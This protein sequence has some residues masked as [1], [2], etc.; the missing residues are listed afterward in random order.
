M[1]KKLGRGKEKMAKARRILLECWMIEDKQDN[2]DWKF[3][4]SY[5]KINYL[6]N[7]TV[8]E[9]VPSGGRENRESGFEGDWKTATN[10]VVSKDKLLEDQKLNSEESKVK[11]TKVTEEASDVESIIEE[12]KVDNLA[13]D[14]EVK[15][16]YSETNIYH[17]NQLSYI[18]KNN[19]DNWERTNFW[20]ETKN[21]M[22]KILKAIYQKHWL[23][24]WDI[25]WKASNDNT[26]WHIVSLKNTKNLAVGDLKGPMS[27]LMEDLGLSNIFE[28]FDLIIERAVEVWDKYMLNQISTLYWIK[29][30]VPQVMNQRQVKFWQTPN[31]W[32]NKFN[33]FINIYPKPEGSQEAEKE[34]NRVIKNQEDHDAL[35]AWTNWYIAEWPELQ[36]MKSAKN[37][38]AEWLRKDYSWI[39]AFEL[40]RKLSIKNR[41]PNIRGNRAWLNNQFSLRAL[42][43]LTNIISN[44]REID[45]NAWDSEELARWYKENWITLARPERRQTVPK[46]QILEESIEIQKEKERNAEELIRRSRE[47]SNY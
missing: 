35:M 19:L 10:A 46:E 30:N 5:V 8:Q 7:F 13:K 6:V 12:I 40:N 14:I 2:K 44:Q 24:L 23:T 31:K 34:Y 26:V 37:Y 42:K 25:S 21:Y 43:K 9:S 38:L 29:K 16:E 28:L 1:R 17:N 18:Q 4:K 11:V 22:L 32:F 15:V 47:R 20:N 33:E 45:I 3:W 27:E 41:D 39:N 36:F